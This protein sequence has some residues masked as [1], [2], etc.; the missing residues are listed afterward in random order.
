MINL[1]T[2]FT[3]IYDLGHLAYNTRAPE[4]AAVICL[5]KMCTVKKNLIGIF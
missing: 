5:K 4:S 3:P 1:E 2:N